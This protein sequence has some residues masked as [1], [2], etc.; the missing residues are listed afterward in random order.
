MHRVNQNLSLAMICEQMVKK[1]WAYY[2]SKLFRMEKQ[3]II[4][5]ENNEMLDLLSCLKVPFKVK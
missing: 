3:K 2:P 1:G 4:A 5:L